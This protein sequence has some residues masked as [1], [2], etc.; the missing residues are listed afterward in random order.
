[1]GM[2]SF[3]YGP[4]PRRGVAQPKRVDVTMEVCPEC[5]MFYAPGE[6]HKCEKSDVTQLPDNRLPQFTAGTD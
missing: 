6:K 3:D 4:H 5:G 1:M 2:P